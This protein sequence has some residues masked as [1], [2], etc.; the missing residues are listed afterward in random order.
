MMGLALALFLALFV[1]C[2]EILGI[3]DSGGQMQLGL[4]AS[5]LFGIICGYRVRT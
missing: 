4:F 2:G 5:F 1:F 3:H